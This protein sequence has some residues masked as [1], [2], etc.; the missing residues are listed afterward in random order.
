MIDIAFLSLFLYLTIGGIYKGFTNIFFK[1][2][3]LIA[4][5]LIAIPFH[6]SLSV[7]MSHFFGGNI[8]IIDLLSFIFI[9][10]LSLSVSQF[11]YITLRQYIHKKKYIKITDR[12]AGFILGIAIFFSILYLLNDLSKNNQIINLLVS[13]SKIIEIFRN[14]G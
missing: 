3:G 2:I 7:F 1:Y 5:I 10:I 8:M 4:G 11:L 6:K 9:V 13:K 12:I 14:L